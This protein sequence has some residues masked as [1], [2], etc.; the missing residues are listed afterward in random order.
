MQLPRLSELLN[1]RFCPGLRL[2]QRPTWSATRLS[3]AAPGPPVP[4]PGKEDGRLRLSRACTHQYLPMSRC[5]PSRALLV[6]AHWLLCWQLALRMQSGTPTSPACLAG[7]N[8]AYYPPTF[9]VPSQARS[10]SL[11]QLRTVNPRSHPLQRR[12]PFCPTAVIAGH[13]SAQ[14]PVACGHVRLCPR[15]ALAAPPAQHA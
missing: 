11:G 2:D 4:S 1:C 6:A 13:P 7:P 5:T 3:P 9:C 12:L 10:P 14:S 8:P 15:L